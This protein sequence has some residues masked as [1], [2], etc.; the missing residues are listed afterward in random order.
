MTA[1]VLDPD[2]DFES[3]IPR[4]VV[5]KGNLSELRS[6]NSENPFV[7]CYVAE[8]ELPIKD[9][10]DPFLIPFTVEL[11]D[12][13]NNKM[14]T[15]TIQLQDLTPEIDIRIINENNTEIE[16]INSGNLELL[17]ISIFDLDD[18]YSNFDVSLE[19]KWPGGATQ[20]FEYKL[21]SPQSVLYHPLIGPDRSI[22]NGDIEISVTVYGLHESMIQQLV[23]IPL[24]LQNPKINYINICNLDGEIIDE[25][26][27]G[28]PFLVGIE[29][30]YVRPIIFTAVS[31]GQDDSFVYG[32]PYNTLMKSV[33]VVK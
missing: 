28:I 5:S 11:Y 23:E 32:V 19:I 9:E 21:D 7:H 4:F 15:R 22:N 31:L 25:I 6:Q 1:C 2:H 17:E 16:S 18:P 10:L 13:K 14:S 33:L 20:F 29:S 26:T 30:Q 8:Y 12:Y 24:L 27:L 3:E